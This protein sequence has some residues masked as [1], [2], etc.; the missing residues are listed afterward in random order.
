M[1]WS[2]KPVKVNMSLLGEARADAKP[3][4]KTNKDRISSLNPVGDLFQ[5]RA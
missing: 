1:Y 3:N 4:V 2:Y 5:T